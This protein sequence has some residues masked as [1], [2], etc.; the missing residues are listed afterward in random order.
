VIICV[1]L[2]P[3]I[4]HQGNEYAELVSGVWRD[5]GGCA[6]MAGLADGNYSAVPAKK[7]DLR[8]GQKSCSAGDRIDAEIRRSS[9]A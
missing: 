9:P 7:P 4:R 6:G 2:P 1:S 5:F 3:D 8:S